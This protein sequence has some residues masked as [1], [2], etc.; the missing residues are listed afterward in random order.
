MH[1][2]NRSIYTGTEEYDSIIYNPVNITQVTWTQAQNKDT[3]LIDVPDVVNSMMVYSSVMENRLRGFFFAE[4]TLRVSIFVQGMTAAY[5]RA[6]L[7]LIP[8][9]KLE[10]GNMYDYDTRVNSRILPHIFIDPSKTDT[11][12]LD[13]PLIGYDGVM[14]L[15]TP[16]KSWHAILK[17]YNALG[18]GT[19]MVPQ[20]EIQM[21]AALVDLKLRGKVKP[22][23][24]AYSKLIDEALD[25]NQFSKGLKRLSHVIRS[26]PVLGPTQTLSTL[27]ES[28]SHMLELLGYSR[29]PVVNYQTTQ[30]RTGDS[31]TQV[32]GISSATV[33]GRSQIMDT[34][35]G[36][37]LMNGD[38]RDMNLSYL[39]DFPY[40]YNTFSILNTA[41]SGGAPV[42]FA[43]SPW[44][45][46]NGT[47]PRQLAINHAAW[48]GGI[49]ISFEFVCSIFHRATLLLAY[50]PNG[51]QP[52]YD[53]AVN[54]LENVTVT[55]S[56]NTHTKW[57]I[58]WRQPEAALVNTEANGRI[59]MFVVNPP[60][61]NNPNSEI[62]ITIVM[63]F[64]D[65]TFHFPRHQPH[66]QA[67]LTTVYSSD[68]IEAQ[69]FKLAGVDGAN[70][71]GV[72]GG[73]PSR[74]LKDLV[75]K[76]G[77]YREDHDIGSDN[78]VTLREGYH[79]AGFASDWFELLTPMFYGWRSS[80]RY[81]VIPRD[82][83]PSR[84]YALRDVSYIYDED[85]PGFPT[86]P[87]SFEIVNTN[88]V[89]G[90]DFV[91]PYVA[92]NRNFNPGQLSGYKASGICFENPNVASYK[93]DIFR[94]AGDDYV[95]GFYLGMPIML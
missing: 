40:H 17:V 83:N 28:A 35:V 22:L 69:E 3:N 50:S 62:D 80:F 15:S 25:S 94:A 32:D 93:V 78:R 77:W 8:N 29:P 64:R 49:E 24:I 58:P 63:N 85:K 70:L 72:V 82:G 74:S 44:S 11:Y 66:T 91:A 33:L 51:V 53:E 60:V 19:D 88:I 9:T 90:G 71:Y 20:V 18:S 86:L 73:D 16:F 68:W 57:Y 79:S 55:I 5:G 48:T 36:N 38:P 46:S 39:L 37:E 2:G 45:M 23:T 27:T 42:S 21:R 41:S 43:V 4:G 81:H 30:F 47:L 1:D 54:S 34:V 65:V 56:G 7:F 52:T 59:Y 67:Y 92:I 6:V 12:S 84:I 26:L 61:S 75:S 95:V 87:N 10:S 13:V 76:A 31:L 14:P 89:N